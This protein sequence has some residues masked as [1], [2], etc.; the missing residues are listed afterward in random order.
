MVI[1]FIYACG[2]GAGWQDL[3]LCQGTSLC[4][5]SCQLRWGVQ[6]SDWS[7]S[8]SLSSHWSMSLSWLPIFPIPVDIIV[9]SSCIVGVRCRPCIQ[10][11]FQVC[12]PCIQVPVQ[13]SRPCI[14]VPVQV[15]RPYIQVP[16]QVCRPCIQVPVQV[17]RPCIQV[18]VQVCRP[19]IQV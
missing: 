7:I 4:G 5:G 11:P 1:T 17:C 6:L 13:V 19:C 8:Q 3:C 16:V 10:L 18:L 2:V 14:Q 12:R 9:I 15:C